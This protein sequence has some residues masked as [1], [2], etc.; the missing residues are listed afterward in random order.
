MMMYS[1]VMCLAESGSCL[2][3]GF[4]WVVPLWLLCVAFWVTLTFEARRALQHYE[5]DN[6]LAVSRDTF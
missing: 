5:G 1:S 6:R 2:P 4:Q 3:S